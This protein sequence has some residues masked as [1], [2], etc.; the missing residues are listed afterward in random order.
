MIDDAG[1]N[2]ASEP[3]TSA[4]FRL[5]VGYGG[6]VSGKGGVFAAGAGFDSM[7]QHPVSHPCDAIVPVGMV[8]LDLRYTDGWQLALAPRIEGHGGLC[9]H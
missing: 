8:T 3:F 5:G 2:N 1:T 9:N 6:G 7:L 4:A